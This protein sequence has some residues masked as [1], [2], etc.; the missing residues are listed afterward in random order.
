MAFEI[1]IEALKINFKKK[2][3]DPECISDKLNLSTVFSC[4]NQ[5]CTIDS[6]KFHNMGSTTIINSSIVFTEFK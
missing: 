1:E 2:A 6:T 4:S 5:S 3:Y